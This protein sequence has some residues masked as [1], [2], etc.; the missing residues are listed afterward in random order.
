MKSL[1]LVGGGG[2]CHSCIDVIESTKT[3]EIEGVVEL[4]ASSELVIGYP[5]IG[6]NNDLPQLIKNSKLAL[7]TV[8]QIKTPNPRIKLF[9]LLKQLGAELPIVVSPK[10]HISK[11]SFIDE[12]SIV[13]HGA[14]VNSSVQIGRNCIVNS[15]SLLEHGVKVDDHCHI[16]TGALVNGDV[17]I[18]RGSFVGSGAVIKEGVRVGDNVIIG[19]GQVVLRDVPNDAVVKICQ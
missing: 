13:M 7:I 8:G 16:S 2:H 18:G 19:A 1:L 11:H 6:S 3:Y 5:V 10:A 15:Q 12:G 17:T 9:N 14:I 4:T